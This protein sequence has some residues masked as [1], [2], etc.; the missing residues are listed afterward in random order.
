MRDV[1]IK[2]DSDWVLKLIALFVLGGGAFIVALALAVVGFLIWNTK[3]QQTAN[4]P[5]RVNAP[6][7]AIVPLQP[8][9]A[10][11][12]RPPEKKRGTEDWIAEL[13]KAFAAKTKPLK[14]PLVIFPLLDANEIVSADGAA[15]SDMATPSGCA[16]RPAVP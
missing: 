10:P 14:P 4:G 9:A 13:D 11:A 7:P 1:N 16:H 8:P 15:L 5:P 6:P 3:T 2:K 12:L